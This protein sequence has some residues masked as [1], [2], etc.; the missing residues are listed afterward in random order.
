MAKYL[1]GNIKGPKG[2]TGAAGADGAIQYTAG[3]GITIENNVI[4][5]TGG[6][7]GIATETDPVFSASPAAGITAQDI[8]D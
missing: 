7:G 1:I 8:T 4:S 5:A 3:T 2:D 6:G